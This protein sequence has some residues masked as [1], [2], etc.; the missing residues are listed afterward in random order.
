LKEGED[1]EEDWDAV[2]AYFHYLYRELTER[3]VRDD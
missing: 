2:E 3:R 1:E